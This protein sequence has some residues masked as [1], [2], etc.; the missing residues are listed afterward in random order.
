MLL[1]CPTVPKTH[2]VVERVKRAIKEGTKCAL[3]QAG[4]PH[5]F[6]TFAMQHY[7]VAGN[8]QASGALEESPHRTRCGRDFQGAPL[9]FSCLAEYL[10][11]GATAQQ[12]NHFGTNAKNSIFLG[13][14]LPPGG[15]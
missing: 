5:C 2:G 13:W 7:C 6:W 1:A 8:A 10:P 14:S 3:E 4:L 15:E 9:P 12:N 11:E